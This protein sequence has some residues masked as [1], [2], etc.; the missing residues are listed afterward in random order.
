MEIVQ[1]NC[2]KTCRAHKDSPGRMFQTKNILPNSVCPYLYHTLYPYFLGLAYGAKFPYNEM[3]DCNVGCPAKYGVD[4][5]TRVR[6]NDG[7]FGVGENVKEVT[8][9]DIVAVGTCPNHHY[10][11]E[12]IVFPNT[13]KDMY[14]CPAGFNNVFPFMNTRIPRCIDTHAL[15]CPDSKDTIYY[16]VNR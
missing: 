16:E 9:A 7:S 6:P 3:G 13:M 15:R 5:I 1:V 11:G 10:V 8:Y 14:L 12:R 4:C 2:Q